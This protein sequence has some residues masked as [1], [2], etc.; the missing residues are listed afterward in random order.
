MIIVENNKN[1]KPFN[2]F[3]LDVRCKRFI[4]YSSEDELAAIWTDSLAKPVIHIGR[5]SNLLFT[6]DFDGTILHSAISGIE[7]VSENENSALVQVSSGVLFDDFCEWAAEKGL[8]GVENLSLIPGETGA[9]AVQNIG[10]YGAEIKDTV[11]SVRC[12]DTCEKEFVEL[13]NEDCS[14]GYRDSSFKHNRGRYIITAVNFRLSKE[15]APQLSYKALA[16]VFSSKD[17]LTPKIVR[18][19]VIGI[20]NE[21]L[22]DP[23]IIGSA[24]SFF[25][26][27]VVT[28]KKY[29]ELCDIF[30]EVP[31]YD[32][33]DSTVKIPAAFLIE[34]CGWKGY[35]ETNVAVW[36]KQ[37]LVIVNYT[38]KASAKEILELEAKI[39]KSIK[40]KT[41]LELQPEVDHI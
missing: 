2:T 37:P 31:H 1:L 24:G 6:E 40:E 21:K 26:N 12:F 32:L 36:E 5:G 28:D 25:K 8:W 20:R 30:G 15:Y 41:G 4:E 27:P 3:G 7:I 34:K 35:K 13:S 23:A 22:P 14:Y 18:D 17:N 19:T 16:S 10:A 29:Q 9:A 33:P 38:M 39:V 11:F